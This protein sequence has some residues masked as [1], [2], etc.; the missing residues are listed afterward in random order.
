MIGA[1][2]CPMFLLGG[3]DQTRAKPDS[4]RAATGVT[5]PKNTGKQVTEEEAVAFAQ[6]V[7]SAVAHGDTEAFSRALDWNA[8][9][10]TS[11]SGVDAPPKVRAAFAKGA[12]DEVARGNGFAGQIIASVKEGGT[13]EFLRAR[14]RDHRRSIVFRMNLQNSGGINYQEWLL[15]REPDGKIKAIDCYVF[16]SG[17]YMSTTLRRGFIDVAAT[18]SGSLLAKLTGTESEFVKH[19]DQIRAISGLIREHK[20]REA[21]DALAKL[22]EG[23]R[24][25]KMLLLFRIHA[26]RSV[27]EAEYE[28]AMMKYR[29][30]YPDDASIDLLSIDYFHA[31]KQYPQAMECVDRL[32]R[33][34]G[35]DPRL[36]LM[37]AGLHIASGDLK[38]ARQDLTRL[39]EK[40]PNALDAY[41]SLVTV[42]LKEKNFDD[43]FNTLKTIR[44][45]FNMQFGDMT[46]IADYQEFVRSP[47]YKEWIEWLKSQPRPRGSD[48]QPK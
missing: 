5:R 39:L 44:T 23:L 13:F 10:E 24:N 7:E 38:A 27:S 37:R 48:A 2:A 16:V 33:S 17:E 26:A 35:G 47:Q 46:T 22:P 11:M 28:K 9:L 43:V 45:R 6:S 8:M 15:I 34:V 3:C 25:S 12:M 20:N 4:D 30:L 36:E 42:G 41:W 40:E 19:A 14:S 29:E 32:D 31:K 18:S 21:F 1:A